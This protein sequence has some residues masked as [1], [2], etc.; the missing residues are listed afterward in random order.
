MINDYYKIVLNK[1][2]K[3]K[4]ERRFISFILSTIQKNWR[5]KNIFI[6]EAPTGYGKS[7]I[8][9]TIAL[10]TFNEELK[11]IIAFPLRTL[12]EDQFEKFKTL[13]NKEFLGKR[14]MHNP[15]SRY[16]IKPI[17]LTTVDTLSLTFFGIP[18][19]DLDKAVKYWS[20][21]SSGSLGHYLFSITST[22][23]SNLILDEVHLLSDS[24]KSLNFLLALM[25]IVLE[26]DQKLI[27]MSATIPT[28]LENLLKQK[29][30]QS[31]EK[32][33]FVKFCDKNGNSTFHC[34]DEHFINERLNKKYDVTLMDVEEF[35]KYQQ[36]I[37]YINLH[38]D[39]YRRIIVVFN[40]VNDA[41][42]FYNN[43]NLKDF[44]KILLHSRFNEKDKE[45]KIEKLKKLREKE[46]YIIVSTQVIEAG[47]DI[48]SNLFIT[49]IAPANSLVQRIGRF[50][51]Y[52]GEN[53]GKILIWYEVDEKGLLKRLSNGK[54][55][56]KVY[57]WDLTHRTLMQLVKNKDNINFHIPTAK[58]IFGYKD[59]IDSVYTENCFN[60][61]EK[62]VSNLIKILLSFESVSY[63]AVNE[64]FNLE[65]SF[66]RDSLLI[67]IIPRQIISS[68]IEEDYLKMDYS[69][70]IRLLIP[71]S[72]NTFKGFLLKKPPII[73]GIVLKEKKKES[74]KER[75]KVKA[76]E[77]VSNLKVSVRYPS[78]FMRFL[79]KNN[80]VSFMV[81]AEYDSKRGLILNER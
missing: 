63:R 81:D 73:N 51:R 38:K 2:F 6:I 76:L 60:I 42:N 71:I 1:W 34:G 29:L 10:Y 53:N 74:G 27:L 15:E 55:Y 35:N 13:V 70:F 54:S 61:D 23:L 21:T 58:G 48:S 69:T 50:L 26:N 75:L 72:L 45:S 14:Y 43:L 47:V 68:L 3:D 4:S 36:I 28:A 57:D 44:T 19:E 41:I 30:S 16:L 56:Y 18:P 7:T 31:L 8:S 67:S 25:R 5:E 9:A 65:G 78:S 59:L 80:I 79:V 20:G 17:T 12:L 33:L 46:E 77:D 52:E 37:K 24:T 39:K 64:F 32:M 66:V 22:T 11:T 40:T 62:R 49:E